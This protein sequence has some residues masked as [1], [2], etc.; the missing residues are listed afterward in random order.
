MQI[1]IGD[2][3]LIGK[4][5]CDKIKFDFKFNSKNIKDIN[6]VVS[7]GSDLYLSC[8]PAEKWKVNQNP[9]KDIQNILDILKNI[10]TKSFRNI[11]LFS[12]I[13]VYSDCPL[14]SDEDLEPAVTSFNYGNNRRMFEMLIKKELVYEDYKIIRLPALYGKYIKKNIIFDILNNNNINDININSI[15]QW[16]NLEDLHNDLKEI[17]CSKEKIFNLFPE[18][19]KTIDI[20]NRI[21]INNIGMFGNLIEYNFC[22]NKKESRYWN[23]RDYVLSG[24]E[25]FFNANRN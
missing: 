18:P 1:I 13:D 3:G 25:R 19:V 15:Y 7:N 23:D 20:L 2:T 16:Y 5:L 14:M 11:Y 8:L 22:T 6:R 4:T 24:I 10:R 21:G 17:K 12:T 9:T